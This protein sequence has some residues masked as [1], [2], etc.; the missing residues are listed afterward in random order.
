MQA[1]D[2]TWL[3]SRTGPKLRPEPADGHERTCTAVAVLIDTNVLVCRYDTR[4]PRKQE[5]ATSILRGAIVS[6]E[7]RVPHQAIVE[8]VAAMTRGGPENQLLNTQDAL[9]EAEEL[10]VQFPILYPNEA[11]LRTALR[12]LVAYGLSWLDANLWAYAEVY[13]L[14]EILSEDYQHGRLYGSVMVRNPFIG[15]GTS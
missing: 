15:T 6:G 4:F 7:G 10:L 3:V 1:L 13:G 2:A 5:I 11:V 12:G 14:P 8:F 9:R